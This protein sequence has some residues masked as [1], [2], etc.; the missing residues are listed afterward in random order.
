MIHNLD[1]E[2]VEALLQTTFFIAIHY[3]ESPESE[4]RLTIKKMLDKILGEHLE[5]VK[6]HINLLP[7]MAKIV[8][9]AHIEEQ[10]SKLRPALTLE[11]ALETFAQRISHDN[12]G[13]VC[14]ALRESADYLRLHPEPLIT[15]V[16]SQRPDSAI[17][18]ILRALLDCVSKY[19]GVHKE[20]TRHCTEILGQIGCV[21]FHQLETVREHRS[22]VVLKNFKD[23][24][25]ITD[26]GLF[27]IEQVLVPS[28]LSATDPQFQGFL[29]YAMQELL[30]RCG[31]KE[32]VGM[33]ESEILD[34]A[35]IYKKWTAM[36]DKV[37]EV[38]AP[39]LTSCY[40]V[41]P[42]APIAD[43]YPI[44]RSGK[45]Y[46]N[47]LRT[48]VISLLNKGQNVHA[49]LLFEP[50]TRVIRVKDL[51]TAEFL[52]PYLVV[53]VLLG[54]ESSLADKENI[55]NELSLILSHDCTDQ[56]SHL[57]KENMKKYCQ[58]SNC[59]LP[60]QEYHSYRIGRFSY[61]RL[62]H[63][64]DPAKASTW[65]PF[66]RRQEAAGISSRGFG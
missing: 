49:C 28:F 43:E 66:I 53:H 33:Q 62:Q 51:S 55:T 44:F 14:L 1:K 24:V 4:S 60:K 16:L 41:G 56:S 25:E 20:I 39:F 2:D 64:V 32:A 30:D 23:P 40:K 63:A 52:L 47:W 38:V 42:M 37:R 29:S 18:T 10:L 50:L 61:P 6:K 22:I 11:E 9:L 17:P 15:A 35:D 5:S 57:E 45:P 27:L 3:W 58:V 46:A 59:I 54:D 7:S 21:D 13:V 36:P 26:F 34:G 48:F 12:S 65:R 8:P 19:N 31:I